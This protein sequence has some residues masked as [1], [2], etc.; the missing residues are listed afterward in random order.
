MPGLRTEKYKMS[1][2]A[3]RI[4][5]NLHA[6]Q[7]ATERRALCVSARVSGSDPEQQDK[8]GLVRDVSA[9]GIF[10]YSNFAPA[11]GSTITLCF[12]IPASDRASDQESDGEV[13]CTGKV[14]RVVKF[15]EGAATG[16]ALRLEER[17]MTYRR[18]A[19]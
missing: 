5:Q 13:L 6:E 7:R 14:V 16:V 8:I 3:I 15:S 4:M 11:L 10:F 18:Y 17:E 12:T 19:G 9:L 2:R 1:D